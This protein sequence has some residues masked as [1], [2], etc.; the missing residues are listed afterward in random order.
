MFLE[1]DDGFD[2]QIWN[3]LQPSERRLRTN[4]EM[5][6]I[7]NLSSHTIRRQAADFEKGEH[8][9]KHRQT[10][11]WTPTGQRQLRQ[12]YPFNGL[13]SDDDDLFE[14]DI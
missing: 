8:F 10:T 9:V 12:R 7:L 3:T 14:E 5:A 13:L 1:S 6:E 4:K 11:Y 2:F